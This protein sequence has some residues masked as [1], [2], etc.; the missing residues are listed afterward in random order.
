MSRRKGEQNTSPS[1]TAHLSL[2]SNK[3]SLA[4]A[5]FYSI[6]ELLTSLFVRCTLT[7]GL[8]HI[9]QGA[10]D[11][12]QMELQEVDPQAQLARLRDYCTKFRPPKLLPRGGLPLLPATATEE[13]AADSSLQM[14]AARCSKSSAATDTVVEPSE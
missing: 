7:P 12:V 6:K 1:Q 3:I 13:G 9:L 10:I 11:L 8:Q 5:S 4:H 14:I 2:P